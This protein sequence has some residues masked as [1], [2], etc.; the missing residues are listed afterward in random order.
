MSGDDGIAMEEDRKAG[1][2]EK[3]CCRDGKEVLKVRNE[4]RQRKNGSRCAQE[5]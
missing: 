5:M 4:R 3:A 2:E 1:N